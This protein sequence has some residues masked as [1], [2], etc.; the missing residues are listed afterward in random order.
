M[1]PNIASIDKINVFYHTG[2]QPP[3]YAH[4]YS[5]TMSLHQDKPAVEFKLE[6]LDRE[7]LSE[8]D[9]YAEGFSDNDDFKWSGKLSKVWEKEFIEHINKAN[10][11][12]ETKNKDGYGAFIEFTFFEG[13]KEVNALHPAD[14]KDWDYFL[15]EIIQAVFEAGQKEM[16]LEISFVE[17]D[18]NIITDH[19][20][21]VSFANREVILYTEKNS[22][23]HDRKVLDWEAAKRLMKVLYM[24]EPDF[25]KGYDAQPERKGTFVQ[26]GDGIWYNW[27]R[28]IH[29][30][31]EDQDFKEK[32]VELLFD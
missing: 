5:L 7:D 10:W 6:Y 25:E 29:N 31:S 8:E 4:Q 19:S 27:H 28:D 21:Q 18:G 20:I 15:Q 3:P 30:P 17:N 14:S 26:M 16:P 2:I 32:F 1:K 23:Q 9:I 12:K 24:L 22:Q 11:T 13:E